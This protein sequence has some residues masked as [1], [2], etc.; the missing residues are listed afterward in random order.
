MIIYTLIFALFSARRHCVLSTCVEK[1][2]KTL[3]QLQYFSL[4]DT[5]VE[6]NEGFTNKCGLYFYCLLLM[7]LTLLWEKRT[8]HCYTFLMPPLIIK[9]EHFG[10]F[11]VSRRTWHLLLSS[12]LTGGQKKLTTAN[13]DLPLM[14]MF[15]GFYWMC[16]DKTATFWKQFGDDCH[17]S[18]LSQISLVSMYWTISMCFR[19]KGLKYQRWHRF[20]NMW[21]MRIFRWSWI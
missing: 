6:R 8:R 12:I 17:T 14:D 2:W 7:M 18:L 5:K 16:M 21:N 4:G 20:V 10:P 3:W 15:R 1:G 19:S 11:L 9:T 13:V